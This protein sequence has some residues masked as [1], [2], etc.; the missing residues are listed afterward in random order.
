MDANTSYSDSS[1]VDDNP[2][3]KKTTM[4]QTTL[5]FRR[6][7]RTQSSSECHATVAAELAIQNFSRSR[8]DETFDQ[9]YSVVVESSKDLT[10]PPTLPRIRRPPTKPGE[11]S[12]ASHV[13]TTPANYFRK[14]YFETL[15]L[16]INE[17]K[18]QFQQKR[19]LPVAAM[20]EK[21]LLNACDGLSD[22]GDFPEEIQQLYQSDLDPPR[23]K[24]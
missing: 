3:P 9:F 17:L 24:V 10:D 15:N 22:S 5:K 7:E 18:S 1:D 4:R 13:F 6:V 8:S 14:Q 16:L 21:V 20:I 12:A 11:T 19:G 2:P 23:L